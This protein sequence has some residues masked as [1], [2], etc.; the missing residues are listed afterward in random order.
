MKGY[1]KKPVES[2]SSQI[3]CNFYLKI[4]MISFYLKL[5]SG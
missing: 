5:A 3:D 1:L 2:Y 4:C